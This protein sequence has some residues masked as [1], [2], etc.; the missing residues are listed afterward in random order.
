MT[1]IGALLTSLVVARE[2]ER[3]TMEALLAS[4]AT[5]GE[6]L[7][8]KLLP[9]Y[10][11]GMVSLF[12]C[13]GVAVF[14]L[15]VPFRGSIWALWLIGSLFLGS[16]LGLGLL[17]STTTRNQFNAA[18]AALN[19][20]FLP[21]LILSGLI[22]EIRSMPAVIRGITYLVPARNFV[23][24]MQTLFQAGNVW[25]VLLK[26]MAFLAAASFFFVGLTAL[27]T[28]AGWIEAPMGY[29]IL[30]LVI[31]EMQALLRDR[32][33]RM[34]LI[35]PVLLQLAIFPFAS[36][37]EVR[38]NTL[39][40]FNED[41]GKESV[42]L[43]QR[44]SRAKAFT[45]LIVL[46]S[47]PELR[48]T[49][50]TQ[51]AL[52]VLRFPADFSRLVAAGQPATIQA[53]PRRTGSNSGQVAL[54]YAQQTLQSYLDDRNA[55][56][57]TARRGQTSWCGHWFNPNL[58]YVRH[59]IPSLVAIITTISTLIV[60]S[61]SVAREKEQGTFDQLLVSPLTPGMIMVGKG[62]PALL[63]AMAQATIILA[64]GVWIY[65]IPFM[66]SLLL[67]YGSMV[68]YILA[69]AGIGL[70][71]SSMCS[72]QQQ[73][74]LG[75]FSFVMPAILL[76]GFPSPVENMPAWLQAVDWFN[77]LRHFIVIVKGVFI[78]DIGPAV[79]FRS[80]W[81]LLVIAGLSLSAADW[82]FRRRL[83]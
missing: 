27:K 11:L 20:A 36:T 2:W 28:G 29:R 40:V 83:E 75:V 77:P 24:A 67:L 12:I 39:A 51:K 5:R 54:G 10:A 71:I 35:L 19:A 66:G 30:T 49:I 76:S 8:S 7:L 6:L 45:R 22:Y 43:I 4:P 37:L 60:T 52:I 64:A 82:M 9:Y 55:R 1:V 69:L 16:A 13:V 81:P 41:A 48:Q 46:R 61:L 65:R 57:G 70:F 74:F 53:D 33:G 21:A 17:L 47:E 62:V 34:L 58:D 80:L 32:Q 23:T 50:D 79:L 3:G 25:P 38:N 63:V 26:S 44:L 31:K 78:K 59:I 68:F 73:A 15:G 56:P 42:E 14:L 72:N 18:Q